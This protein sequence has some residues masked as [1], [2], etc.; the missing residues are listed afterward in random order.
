[1]TED[2][3]IL[4]F[5]KR[6]RKNCHVLA[7]GGNQS[8]KFIINFK[9]GKRK[10]PDVVIYYKNILYVFEAKIIYENLFKKNKNDFSDEDV[11]QYLLNDEQPKT[12]LIS[13]AKGMLDYLKVP[14][15]DIKIQCGLIYGKTKK[16][17]I[18]KE[19]NLINVYSN[20]CTQEIKVYNSL[21]LNNLLK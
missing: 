2:E 10:S 1:M 8:S 4:N 18:I 6:I 17:T 5:T 15:S 19:T 12:S 21:I 9:D 16:N 3:V 13:H 14:Y 11:M 20:S 7:E